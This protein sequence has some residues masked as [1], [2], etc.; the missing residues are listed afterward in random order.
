MRAIIQRVSEASVKIDGTIHSSIKQGLLVLVGFDSSDNHEDIEKATRKIIQLRIFSDE[1]GLMNKSLKDNKGELLIV[2]QFTLYAD[3]QK[4][5]RPSFV[6][7]A[8]PVIAIP[9]YEAFIVACQ[10]SLCTE[11]VKT[12]VFGEDMAIS[13]I[14]DGPVTICFDSKK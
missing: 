14:N 7:A 2:S 8:S 11:Q 4:G 5:N 1:K 9:L 10:E 3:I 6:K 12:G 13:L